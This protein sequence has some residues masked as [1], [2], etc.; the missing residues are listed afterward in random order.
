MPVSPK[1]AAGTIL[2]GALAGFMSG[3]LGIGGGSL[4]VPLLVLVVGLSQHEAH[5]TSLAG[6]APIAL[7]GALTFGFK[8]EIDYA[9]A[10]LLALGALAGAPLGARLMAALN[11]AP[12][13]LLFGALLFFAALRLAIP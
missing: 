9:V 1:A 5:A 6:I 8:L 13:K 12:L 2:A 4:I 7:V 3:L 10:S 11:E